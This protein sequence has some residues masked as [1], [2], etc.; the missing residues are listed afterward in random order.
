MHIYLND[1]QTGQRISTLV[2]HADWITSVAFNPKDPKYFVSTSLDNTLKIWN[3]G[4]N[5][6]VKTI[7]MGEQCMGIWSTAFSPDG[8]YL[9]VCC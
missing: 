4:H 3:Q 5:K 7:H 8:K 1:V 6:E 2:N 9:V